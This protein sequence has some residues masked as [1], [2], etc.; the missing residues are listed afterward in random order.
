M[1]LNGMCLLVLGALTSSLAWAEPTVEELLK[2]TDDVARGEHSIAVIEMHVV[3]KRYERTMKMRAWSMGTE[4]T[5]IQ[6]LA[7]AKDAGVATLKVADNI[8]NYLPKVD[9]TMKVPAGMM[10]GSWMGSHFSNDDLVKESRLSEDFTAKITSRPAD[11]EAKTYV[12]E[13]VPK[14]DA[15][16]VWGRIVT[17]V[18]ADL[19]PVDVRYYDEKEALV[20]T[21]LFEDIKDFGGRKI[22]ARMVLVPE[23]KPGEKTEISYLELDF[24]TEIPASKFTLQALRP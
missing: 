6:I 8:W 7:P 1:K 21:M 20:R 23:N 17:R 11:N 14:P 16:V 12:I 2:A 9:R 4:K 24:T 15:P 13:L 5:L 3:S 18:S 22:P 10:S 19:L